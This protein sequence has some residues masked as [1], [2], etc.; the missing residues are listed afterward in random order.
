M[1]RIVRSIMNIV[2]DQIQF[3]KNNA[4]IEMLHETLAMI[5]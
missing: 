1:A 4:Q 2:T 3:M 5:Y